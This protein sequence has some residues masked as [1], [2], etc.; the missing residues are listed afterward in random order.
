M[1]YGISRPEMEKQVLPRNIHWCGHQQGQK[2]YDE[3]AVISAV[4][5]QKFIEGKD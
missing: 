1:E 3:L 5:V 2:Y 4:V